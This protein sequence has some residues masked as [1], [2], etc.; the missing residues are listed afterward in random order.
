M[1][2]WYYWMVLAL[3]AILMLSIGMLIGVRTAI[4]PGAPAFKALVDLYSAFGDVL[5]FVSALA[6]VVLGFSLAEM[7]S[8]VEKRD[9]QLQATRDWEEAEHKPDLRG[10]DL[11]R[12]NLYG[13]NLAGAKLFNADLRKADLSEAKLQGA[14]LAGANLKKAKLLAAVLSKS[15]ADAGKETNLGNAKLT[16]ADMRMAILS[17]AILFGADLRRANLASANLSNADLRTANLKGARLRKSNLTGAD[18]R[19]AD[20]HKA[21]LWDANL[22]N[23]NLRGAEGVN[24][25]QLDR[26][27]SLRGATL[28]DG[29]THN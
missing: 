22:S 7:R 23:V 8:R 2:E 12:A 18:L 27:R 3:V 24:K 10:Y 9:K 13:V 26:A 20:L 4:D 19:G 16:G 15:Q 17:D 11:R 1:F 6:G 29:T 28:P 25:K 21:D 5:N 14:D